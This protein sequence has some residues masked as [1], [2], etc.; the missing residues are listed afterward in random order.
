MKQMIRE[1]PALRRR[2]TDCK[3]L[4]A[5]GQSEQSQIIAGL[6]QGSSRT[7]VEFWLSSDR[8]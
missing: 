5:K 1:K 3:L 7:F 6:T 8:I 4:R 2:T